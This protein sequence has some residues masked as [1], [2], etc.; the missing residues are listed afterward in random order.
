MTRALVVSAR[1]P[2][3]WLA[4][5]FRPG[6]AAAVFGGA[7]ASITDERVD[8]GDLRIDAAQLVERVVTSPDAARLSTFG[9]W[10]SGA[11]RAPRVEPLVARATERLLGRD[12]PTVDV[13][14]AELG[15]TRQHLTRTLRA[16]VG[17]G[18]KQ[19]ARVGRLKR[20]LAAIDRGDLSG[21]AAAAVDAGYYDQS[22]LIA[23]TRALAGLTPGQLATERR[24]SISPIAPPRRV[25]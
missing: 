5:R 9:A 2:G 4:V 23:E 14:A 15:V 21:W 12:A 6:G 24:G 10:V 3:E 7:V 18:A 1:D 17:I 8:L 22:H 20:V 19:I 11:R 16:H 13:L 25:A